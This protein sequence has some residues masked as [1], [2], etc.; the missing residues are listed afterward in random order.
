M[1]KPD[2]LEIASQLAALEAVFGS[3]ESIEETSDDLDDE[4]EAAMGI[5]VS[6]VQTTGTMLS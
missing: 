5:E 2:V 4:I 1:L 6:R 3:I